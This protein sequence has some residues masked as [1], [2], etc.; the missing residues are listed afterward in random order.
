MNDKQRLL[1][2]ENDIINLKKKEKIMHDM[3]KEIKTQL[4]FK[5]EEKLILTP[6]PSDT[7]FITDEVNTEATK[8]D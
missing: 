6:L 4:D 7:F 8:D 1:Q 2:A 3:L 5:P